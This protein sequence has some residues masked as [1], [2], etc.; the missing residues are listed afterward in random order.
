MLGANCTSNPPILNGSSGGGYV[1]NLGGVNCYVTGSPLLIF[2]ILLASDF[3]GY[4]APL[5]RKLADKVG[6]KGYHVVVPDFFNGDPFDPNNA[7]RPQDIW[8]KDHPP[9]KGIETAKVVVE[10]LKHKGAYAIGAAGFCWGGKPAVDLGNSG[11]TKVTV[12]LHPAFVT[13]NDIERTNISIAILGGQN[14]TITPPSQIKQYE[15]ILNA[16]K[17]EVESLVKI[18]PGVSHGWT[19]RYDPNDP[20]AVKDAEKAHEIM[21]DWF[22][23]HLKKH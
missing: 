4:Q 20:E 16:K 5:L 15:E 6:T 10:A 13:N 11:H 22:D 2:V 21:L 23:K 7:S 1:T 12:L 9:E 19:L 8:L 14:D 3:Y 17:P 18:F